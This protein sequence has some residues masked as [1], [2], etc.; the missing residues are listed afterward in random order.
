MENRTVVV[1]GA[2]GGIGSAV[3]RLLADRGARLAIAGRTRDRL[4]GL[5]EELGGATVGELDATR[6][7]EK[8]AIH[9]LQGDEACTDLKACCSVNSPIHAGVQ[10]QT[11]LSQLE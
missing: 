3:C 1:L 4:E 8:Q 11:E 5:A 10:R 9:L 6:F 7:A 2:S